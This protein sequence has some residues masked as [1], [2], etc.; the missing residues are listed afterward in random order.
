MLDAMQ[1]AVK[2][3]VR[4][5]GVVLVVGLLFLLVVT[6]IAVTAAN[7]S[8]LGLKMSAS[9]Q[10][11]YRSFQAAEAG[12]YAA[13]GLAGT[14]QDPF[15]RQDIIEEPFQGL[16]GLDGGVNHPLR[17]QA[18]DP[19]SVPVDVDVLLVATARACPRPPA[20]RGGSSVSVFDCDYYRIQSEH[21]EPGRART[22]VQLGVVKMVI[23]RSSQ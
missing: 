6:I 21:V 12:L 1:K 4:E 22:Q 11:S 16:S 2:S 13:L 7:N 19:S 17:N 5:S 20:A 9:M 15:R 18:A 10:D 23:G 3:P 14:A 8:T